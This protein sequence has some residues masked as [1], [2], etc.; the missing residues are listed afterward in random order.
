MKEIYISVDIEAAGPVPVTYSMLSLGA[1]VVGNTDQNF[2]V[3]LQPINDAFIQ[4]AIE[5]TGRTLSDFSKTGI[6]PKEAM[7][8]FQE[9]VISINNPVFVGFNAPFDWSF[10]NWYFHTFLGENPF[11]IGGIDIKAYYMGI[12]GCLWS[13]TKSSKIPAQFKGITRHTHNALDD[14]IE[15]AEMFE[16]MYKYQSQKH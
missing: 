4:A 13:E 14:A 12:T 9:W 11:G 15:Q 1:C 5:V 8:K 16:L 6:P 2:Y 10:V 3:E 7:R